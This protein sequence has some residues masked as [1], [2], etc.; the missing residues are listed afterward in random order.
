MWKGEGP[1]E[2]PG[3][4][5]LTSPASEIKWTLYIPT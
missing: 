2:G 5:V 4:L 1:G 3:S